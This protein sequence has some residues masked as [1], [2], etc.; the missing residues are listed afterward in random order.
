VRDVVFWLSGAALAF[1]ITAGAFLFLASLATVSSEKSLKP[2]PPTGRSGSAV[3]LALDE[4]HLA[5][6][7]EN[8]D[9]SLELLV[10][11]EGGE[12]LSDVNVTLSVSSE[13]TA[14][15]NTRYYRRTVERVDPGGTAS[16]RF[17]FDLSDPER[18]AAGRPPSE[19]ARN[20]LEFRA[21]TP[22]GIS[23]VRTVILPP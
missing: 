4:G 8:Q 5:S 16:V 10:K 6:L 14:L 2:D 3:E 20:I 12:R 19:P 15:P 7:G 1:F 21:T 9:Q 18:P 22:E 17:E 13:N 11:N 23:T